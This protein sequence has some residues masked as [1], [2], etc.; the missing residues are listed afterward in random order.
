MGPKIGGST[1]R[2]GKAQIIIVADDDAEAIRQAKTGWT[3]MLGDA[4]YAWLGEGSDDDQR[5]VWETGSP[6]A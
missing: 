6:H 4:D 5:L 2:K 1:V 3:S